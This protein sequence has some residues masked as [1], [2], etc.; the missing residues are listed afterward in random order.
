MPLLQQFDPPAFLPDFKSIPGQF[1]AWH[2]AVLG[3]FDESIKTTSKKV[4]G[5]PI[6]FFNPATFDPGGVLVDQEITWNAFPKQLLREFGRDKAL[7][8]A[9]RLWHIEQYF[10]YPSN[11]PDGPPPGSGLLY[12]PQEE[13]CEWHVLRDSGSGKIQRVTFTSEPPEYW[14][15]LTGQVPGSNVKFPSNMELLLK[16][17]RKL[18]HPKVQ[19]ADLIATA[20]VNDPQGNPL[21]RKGQYN[22][23]NQWNTTHGIAHLNSPP[24]S[25]QAEIQLGADASIR[26]TNPRG[27][28]LV[29]PEALI[30]YGSYGGPN[31]NS[32]PTIGA[33]VNALSRL[34]AYVTLRNPVGLYMDHIDLSGWEAPDG[35]EVSDCVRVLRG[36]PGMIERMVVQAPPNRNFSVGDI[37]INGAPIHYGGQIAECITVKLVGT[38]S[39]Q[40]TPIA[41]PASG[42]LSLG[43][44]DPFYPAVV[45]GASLKKGISP[46]NVE[47]FL[48]EG[49]SEGASPAAAP[50]AVK[51]KLTVPMARGIRKMRGRNHFIP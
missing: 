46:G 23:Y 3:W 18:V 50:R 47:A 51:K 32:D 12:R 4:G 33:S 38:A 6:Q 11:S 36:A 49:T 17:Y 30:A 7:E 26:Y 20:D 40:P 27:K 43:I 34:G 31:R 42:P 10:Q 16:L 48:D 29:E 5:Q 44:L 1:A 25:L 2:R 19:M 24:N 28:L 13:Y 37:T 41:G 45:G 22:I 14:Q 21:T 9:D 15:A 35:R 39:I 8:L